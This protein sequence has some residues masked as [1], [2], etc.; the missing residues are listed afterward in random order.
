MS[1]LR[2]RESS[3]KSF[4]WAINSGAKEFPQILFLILLVFQG[5]IPRTGLPRK[6]LPRLYLVYSHLHSLE[7]NCCKMK[8]FPMK[9]LFTL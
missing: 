9:F 2:L 4:V 7:N 1:Q 3:G 5:S 6:W 8:T